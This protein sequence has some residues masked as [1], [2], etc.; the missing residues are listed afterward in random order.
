MI[1]TPCYANQSKSPIIPCT[2]KTPH[3]QINLLKFSRLSTGTSTH[4]RL[5]TPSSRRLSVKELHSLTIFIHSASALPEYF[6]LASFSAALSPWA[7]FLGMTSVL[8][9]GTR[10][11]SH[12]CAGAGKRGAG[13]RRSLPLLLPDPLPIP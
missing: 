9:P 11:P 10:D 4:F 2:K 6:A 7:G 5:G 13:I 1:Q 8:S 3:I 12:V